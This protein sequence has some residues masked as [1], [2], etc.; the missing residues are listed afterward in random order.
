[1]GDLGSKK[2][3]RL[4]NTLVLFVAL[5]TA[6]V[7][8]N[9][10]SVYLSAQ[11]DLTDNNVNSLSLESVETLRSMLKD[12]SARLEVRLYVSRN[13]PDS[14]KGEWQQDLVLRGVPQKLRDKVEEFRSQSNGRLDVVEVTDDVEKSAE[15]AGLQPFVAEEATV[16]E[17]KLEMTRY[18]LGLTLAWEGEVEVFE[19]ALDP[20][21]F[22]FEITKRLLRLKDR[23]ENGRQIQHLIKTADQLSEAVKACHDEVTAFEV[24][25]D[26]K[27]EVSG[28]EGLLKPIENMEQEVDALAKN[29]DRI[30]EK[31]APIQATLAAQ[32]ASFK[33]QNKRFDAFL[34]GDGPVDRVGGVEAY[35][36]TVD[37]LLKALGESQ[38]DVEA[39]MQSKN[40]LSALK[41]DIDNYKEQLRKAPGQRRIGFV[42]GHDEFC[43]FA[44]LKPVIDPKI[45]QMMGQQNPIQERFIQVA[46]G[47][48]EQVNQILQSIGSGLFRDRDFEVERV[49]ATRTIGDDIAALVVFGARQ[50]LGEREKYE[51]DQYLLRG[52]TVLVFVANYDAALSSF[53]EEQIKK[54]GPFNPNPN[55]TNDF[56]S[57]TKTESN[58]DQLLSAYGIT[59]NDDLIMDPLNTNKITLPHSVRRGRMVISGTKDFDYPLLVYARDFD[60]ANVVVRNL[61]GL[62]LPFASSLDYTAREGQELEVSRLITSSDKSVSV[63]DPVTVTP[64]K[65]LPPELMAQA[66]SLTPTGPHTLAIMATGKFVSAFKGKEA[67]AKPPRETNPEEPEPKEDKEPARVDEGSGRLMVMGSALG[68]PP[69][70]LEG[71]FKDVNIQSITQGEVLVPQVRFENWKLKVNQLRRAFSETIPALFNML[72]WGVQRAALAEIRAKNNAFRPIERIEEGNQKLVAYAAIGGVPILFLLFG[73]AYWQVRQARRRGLSRKP[74][75]R[76]EV[77]K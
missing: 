44:S 53:S 1:M 17:G 54:M 74:A 56:V 51:I 26:E 14:I 16:K 68:L 29:R 12:D 35:G 11:V 3:A 42:C 8:V 57:L 41:D 32:A 46:L 34:R 76:T 15:A 55:I 70:T 48:Q 67:P 19:K 65:L 62:T 43:P 71:V 64:L 69:L 6:L 60:R 39:V 37:E 52:G 10:V 72:D 30:A 22:E 77:A 9:V 38:Q 47:L 5:I 24:K 73:V 20:S 21:F 2:K 59:V 4:A 49:D 63:A 28:I 23:V 66:Q 45:A 31:C 7:L 18:V 36:K 75:S 58:V 33:G 27:Q 40:L 13:L 50:A 25:P 61:P